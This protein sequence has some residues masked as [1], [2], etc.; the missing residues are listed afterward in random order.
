[1]GAFMRF[2]TAEQAQAFLDSKPEGKISLEGNEATLK[3][4]EGEEEAAYIEKAS[5]LDL[6]LPEP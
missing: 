4:L 3:T 2:E 6:K 1:M 5:T